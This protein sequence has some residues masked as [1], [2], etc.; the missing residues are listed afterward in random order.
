[1][2]IITPLHAGTGHSG[3]IRHHCQSKTQ[4]DQELIRCCQ[5]QE[6]GKEG[7]I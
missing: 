4:R 2:K 7:K 5:E 3:L 1:M 6:T